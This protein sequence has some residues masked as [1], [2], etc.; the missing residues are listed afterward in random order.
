MSTRQ[1]EYCTFRN[2]TA[3]ICSW[4]IDS[5]K[6]GDLGGENAQFLPECLNSVDQ[7]DIIVFGFQEVIPLTDKKLTASKWL[8]SMEDILTNNRDTA[9]WCWQTRYR[10]WGQSHHGLPT[11]GRQTDP[12]PEI[13]CARQYLS[14]GSFRQPGRPD[15]L[16]IR[17]V[18]REGEP[19]RS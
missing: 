6:P 16:H 1:D 3:M 9:L 15:D 4:N 12:S 5:A 2:V 10:D 18:E 14:K 19:P 13:G 11:L 17:Q 7:P 8:M